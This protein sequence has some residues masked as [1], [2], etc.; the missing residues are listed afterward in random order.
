MWSS[1]YILVEWN[2]VIR[3]KCFWSSGL[4]SEVIT[5]G[6]CCCTL[7][8]FDFRAVSLGRVSR[9]GPLPYPRYMSSS[10]A[11]EWIG[12]R[13]EKGLKMIPTRILCFRGILPRSV[14][15]ARTFH[16]IFSYLDPFRICRVNL[17]RYASSVG[18]V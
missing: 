9:S 7:N 14:N 13:V 4:H 1:E 11:P 2:W 16:S 17:C 5:V 10:L 18:A 15:H 3:V 12:V 6:R 8:V